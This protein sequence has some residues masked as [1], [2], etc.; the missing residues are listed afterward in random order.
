M[1]KVNFK[2]FK[3]YTDFKKQHL[4]KRDIR[5]LLADTIYCNANGVVAAN[6]SMKIINSDG[7]F[8]LSDNEIKKLIELV[9]N[10]CSQN[11]IDGIVEMLKEK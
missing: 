10:I 11:I 2:E 1:K 3:F 5:E 9:S 7:E 6:L 8:E 4:V